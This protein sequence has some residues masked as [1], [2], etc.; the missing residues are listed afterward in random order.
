MAERDRRRPGGDPA[1][2][3]VAIGKIDAATDST[4]E[5]NDQA[6]VALTAI[7]ESRLATILGALGDDIP[8]QRVIRAIAERVV[9]E[10]RP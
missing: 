9:G 2:A 10:R 3:A 6:R 5:C 4:H 1:A 8:A 7:V